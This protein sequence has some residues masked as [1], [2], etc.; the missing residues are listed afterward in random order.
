MSVT[1]RITVEDIAVKIATYTKI[2]VESATSAEGSYS[3]IGEIT[4]VADTYDYSYLDT[5]GTVNTWYR[6]RFSD[7]AQ[8]VRSDY[9]NPFKPSG[10]SRLAVRQHAINTYR[11]GMVF[12]T[13]SSG[14]IT[15]V[16]TDDPLIKTTKFEDGRGKGGWLQPNAG[17]DVGLT[18]Y[19]TESSPSTGSFTVNP[20]YSAEVDSREVEWHWMAPPT[21]WNAAINRACRRYWYLDRVPIVGVADQDE[22][23]LITL[24]W[25]LSER[26]VV[27]LWHYPSQTAIATL[28]GNDE[29]WMGGKWWK[30]TTDMGVLKLMIKPTI[31]A[32]KTL[33]LEAIRQVQEV[34][35]DSSLFP[36]TVD[37]DCMSALA[38]DEVLAHLTRPGF[39]A[40][41][42]RQ[43]WELE[44]QKHSYELMRHLNRVKPKFR[45]VPQGPDA[46]WVVPSPVKA[47]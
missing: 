45:Y 41:G 35:S 46:P 16:M 21:V 1:V 42:E 36:A 2:E 6:Y 38:Y 43:A 34:Y 28:D 30:I 7:A 18:R 20:A 26:Q 24:P 44:R 3:E 14:S 40:S 15:A 33:F 25:L 12:T 37:I 29:P 39:G 23:S 47:R 27:G 5:A 8:A 22:Y 17:A 10:L 32:T 4:L 9:S 11:A 19:I 13:N 31:P